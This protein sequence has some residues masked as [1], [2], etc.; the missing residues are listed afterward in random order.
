MRGLIK[1][2]THTMTDGLRISMPIY[3]IVR[4][5]IGGDSVIRG[6]KVPTRL[7]PKHPRVERPEEDRSLPL[8]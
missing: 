6:I 1:N 5:N 2:V 7:D 8:C 4:P 3:R